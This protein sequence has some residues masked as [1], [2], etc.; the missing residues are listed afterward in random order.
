MKK[1]LGLLFAIFAGMCVVAQEAVV[2]PEQIPLPQY[3]YV[4]CKFT[5]VKTVPNSQTN[6]QSGGNFT[7][8]AQKGVVFETLYPV[9]I[10]TYYTSEQN[11]RI[12]D[13]MSA[14]ARKDYSYLSKNFDMFL[15]K[16]GSVW[17][18]T[19]KPKKS[20]KPASV[21]ESL[22]IQGRDYVTMININTLSSGSTKINFSECSTPLSK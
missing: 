19:L 20:A 6:L 5:Q 9:K 2:K 7:F 3:K 15:D 17:T 14:A 21:M 18:L 10:T 12:S 22:V 13:I 11:R 4:S 8:D 1:Y 16:N